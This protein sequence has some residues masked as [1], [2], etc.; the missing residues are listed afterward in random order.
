[1]LLAKINTRDGA[2]QTIVEAIWLAGFACATILG[3][4]GIGAKG[5]G[6]AAVKI[7][8]VA[9]ALAY[10]VVGVSLWRRWVA[11]AALGVVLPVIH[12][13]LDFTVLMIVFD[14]VVLWFQVNG[15]RGVLAWRRLP[16]QGGQDAPSTG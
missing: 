7:E 14:G 15:L 16:A 10:V 4:E 1:V 13:V 9:I 5:F 6:M 3:V 11:G 12:L 8:N 2:R